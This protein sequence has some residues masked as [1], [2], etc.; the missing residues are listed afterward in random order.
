MHVYDIYF[1]LREISSKLKPG[2]RFLIN[3]QS[4][5]TVQFGRDWFTEIAENFMNRGQF[6]PIWQTSVQFHSNE[7]YYRA[8]AH[9][10]MDATR[11]ENAGS[12]TE[13]VFVK[14]EY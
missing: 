5:D 8:A 9:F 10:G 3:W 7:F 1:Y 6:V 11:R 4:A 13:A 12:Y 14:R 2:G